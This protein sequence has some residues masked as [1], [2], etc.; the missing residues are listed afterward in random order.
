MLSIV[1]LLLLL[2]VLL[3]PH[4]SPFLYPNLESLRIE[5]LKTR[6]WDQLIRSYNLKIRKL[7]GRG[8]LETARLVGGRVRTWVWCPFPATIAKATPAP[9]FSACQMLVFKC[10]VLPLFTY[11]S[12]LHLIIRVSLTLPI[13]REWKPHMWLIL[14][15]AHHSSHTDRS[16]RRLLEERLQEWGCHKADPERRDW[17]LYSD[18]RQHLRA[19]F[20]LPFSFN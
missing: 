14:L 2:L 8:F 1:I 9:V 3:L 11:M 20:F 10:S 19:S 15:S 5:E 17:A 4:C 18:P 16:P 6:P 13:S 12:Q 7:N